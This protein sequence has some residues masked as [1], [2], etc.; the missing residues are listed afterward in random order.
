M[1]LSKI[2]KQ[3]C[4]RVGDP[5]PTNILSDDDSSKE[6]FGYISQASQQ[7]VRE[8]TWQRLCKRKT[9]T[10]TDGTVDYDLPN[11]FESIVTYWLYNKTKKEYIN[12]ADDDTFNQLDDSDDVAFQIIGGKIE[13]SKPIDA[14][15]VIQYQYKINSVCKYDDENTVTYKESFDNEDDEFLLDPELLILKAIALRSQN[16]EFADYQTR[17]ADY[18]KY[19]EMKVVEDGAKIHKTPNS[20]FIIKTTPND[21][22]VKR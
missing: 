18:E 4:I 1:K 12:S 11:D 5:V 9:F 6:W 3:C 17:L 14:G 2:L 13:F 19:L 15:N 8:H 20:D 10:T 22:S 16:L 21:W 7:I